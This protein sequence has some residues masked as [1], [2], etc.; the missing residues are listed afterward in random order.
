MKKVMMLVALL[1]CISIIGGRRKITCRLNPEPI[2]IPKDVATP[3][4]MVP[5]A[6][7]PQM[8]VQPVQ[9]AQ[10]TVPAALLP[11]M[12]DID[13]EETTEEQVAGEE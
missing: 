3:P 11:Q 13:R 10:P 2:T 4:L 12:H 5:A 9:T 7:L 6:Q 8:Q 1:F